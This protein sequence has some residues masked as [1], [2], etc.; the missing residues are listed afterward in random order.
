MGAWHFMNVYLKIFWRFLLVFIA[1]AP[2]CLHAVNCTP[3]TIELTTQAEVDNFQENHGPGC[4]TVTNEL[5]IGIRGTE[6][7]EGSD[8]T[9]LDG[10]VGLNQIYGLY[11][12]HNPLLND[13]DGLANVST[14][15]TGL[16]FSYNNSLTSLSGLESLAGFN[17]GLSLYQNPELIDLGSFTVSNGPINRLSISYC[18]KLTNVDALQGIT[19]VNGSLTI[20]DTGLT[21]LTVFEGV[22][23]IEGPL[24]I[25]LNEALNSVDGL[26]ALENVSGDLTIYENNVLADLDGLAGL[27][28]VDGW[29]HVIRNQQLMNIDGLSSLSRV[30]GDFIIEDSSEIVDLNSLGALSYVGGR[31]A[32]LRLAKLGEIPGL[33][34]L[35]YLGGSLSIGANESLTQINGFNGLA[36]IGGLLSIG[37]NVNLEE[38]QGFGALTS[39]GEGL[40]LG[41]NSSLTNIAGLASLESAG[42]IVSIRSNASLQ[43]LDDLANIETIGARVTVSGNALITDLDWMSG[44]TA[45]NDDLSITSNPLLSDLSGLAG[46]ESIGGDLEIEGNQSL[47]DCEPLG[48]LLDQNDDGNP[49][50][51]LPPTPDVGGVI[52]VLDNASGCDSLEE[53]VSVPSL[54]STM[55]G[56]W[57]DPAREG[58]GFMVHSVNDELAVAYYYGFDNEGERFWSIGVYQ[59][60]ILWGQAVTFDAVQVTGGS[61]GDFSQADIQESPWGYMR[62]TLPS[63]DG[64]SIYVG[65]KFPG[66]VPQG[67]LTSVVRLE[68]TAGFACDGPYSQQPVDG[69][70]GSW[71]DP[72]SSGQGFAV[73]KI[74]SDTGVIYFYGFDDA[75]KPLWLIG[76]WQGLVSFGSEL[77]LQMNQVTGGTFEVVD[78][79]Q[80]TETPWG[81]LRI[82][83]DGCASG[84]AE[85]SGEDGTQEFDLTLLAGSEGIECSS[86]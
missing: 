40:R 84:W 58:T 28:N 18:P 79:E 27:E 4:D 21:N 42:E 73:H 37:S 59:G 13:L 11:V 50:P 54:A 51:G 22:S 77:E 48:A 68:P 78:P 63:C 5:W 9:I 43:S 33:N 62:F 56:S 85:L 36:H 15:S 53:V 57:Y 25:A 14:I 41:G 32:L 46:L 67:F 30:G 17:G 26:E 76:T 44:L 38:I 65:G 52:I 2:Q 80:I 74:D 45:I 3:G 31:I 16:N 82:R 19:A 71:Y 29:F 7:E 69:I 8:I 61:F 23:S 81:N 10:L 70:T 47:S 24:S 55:V 1:L 6:V 34:S 66:Y 35:T 39:T 60:P 20:V 49:G 72:D 64:G 83:F 86:G 75:G 12:Q